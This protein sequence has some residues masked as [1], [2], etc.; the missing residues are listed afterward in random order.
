MVKQSHSGSLINN[1]KQTFISLLTF[2]S[3]TL[4]FEYV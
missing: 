3:T 4:V 2:S 1:K